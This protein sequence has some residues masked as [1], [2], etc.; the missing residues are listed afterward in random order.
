MSHKLITAILTFVLLV[1]V[2]WVVSVSWTRDDPKA[3]SQFGQNLLRSENLTSSPRDNAC[4]LVGSSISAHL[5]FPSV[6]GGPDEARDIYNLALAG[7]SAFTGLEL[8]RGANVTP[9]CILVELNVLYKPADHEHVRSVLS[10]VARVV[11]HYVPGARHQNQPLNM[12]LTAV[13]D[14]REQGRPLPSAALANPVTPAS[15]RTAFLME[16][17]AEHVATHQSIPGSQVSDAIAQLRAFIEYFTGRGTRIV[18]VEMP[19]EPEVAATPP[20]REV[21]SAVQD[22]FRATGNTRDTRGA[23]QIKRFAHGDYQTADG[24]H[25]KKPGLVRVARELETLV[26][27]D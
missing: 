15:A 9:H 14:L 17:I 18:L 26:S 23:V 7:G 22:M 24:I 8:L 25:L 21:R 12:L 2:H 20:Y 16:R 10:P 4:V 6:A 5:V 3:A 1:L 19:V 13:R 27:R 11:R